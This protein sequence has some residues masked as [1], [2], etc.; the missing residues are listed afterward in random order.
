MIAG[1]KIEKLHG[2]DHTPLG[3]VCHH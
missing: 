1:V 3:V 2:H